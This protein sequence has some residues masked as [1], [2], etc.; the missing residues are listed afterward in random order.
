MRIAVVGLGKLGSP[1]AAM[2]ASKGHDVVGIDS[3]PAVVDKIN[4][5][6]ATVVEPGLQSL[7]DASGARLS[8]TTSYE[9]GIISSDLSFVIVPTPSDHLGVFSNAHVLAAVR[10]IGSALRSTDKY[11]AVNITSTVMPGSTGGEIRQCLEASSGRKVGDN[12]GLTYNPEFIALGSVVHDLLNPDMVLIGESDKRAGDILES[13]YRDTFDSFAHLQRMNW[14]NAEI[15]K[16]AVNTYVTTKITYANMLS[17]LCERLSGADVDVVT[18]ALG[19]D[20][21]VGPKYL[22]GAIGYGGPCFPRDNVAFARLANGLGVRS[23]LVEAT[24][25]LNIHQVKRLNQLVADISLKKTKV[26]V[27]GLAYKPATPVID[28]SQGV[29]L[30]SELVK[31]GHEVIVYDPLATENTLAIFGNKVSAASSATEAVEKAGIVVITT[32]CE[33][34]RSIPTSAFR[35]PGLERLLVIDCWRLLS[36]EKLM[37]WADVIYLGVSYEHAIST[38]ATSCCVEITDR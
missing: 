2:F 6:K 19:C 36:R 29:M 23:D 7:I 22:R 30:T 20:S 11:H 14:I 10:Q 4:S 27:L 21:R 37:P 18:Q 15:T 28:E 16:L 1:L 38:P 24:Q 25:K 26:A 3:N 32:A 17:E 8:A 5:G 13:L 12:L 34:F 35:R 9:D 31:A 33:E